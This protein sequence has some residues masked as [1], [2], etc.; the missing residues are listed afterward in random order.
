[1]DRKFSDQEIFRREKLKKLYESQKD[2]FAIDKFIRNFNSQ[3]FKDKYSE[4]TK[5]ELHEKKDEIIVA[6]RL[7]A[8]RQTFGVIKDFF[9][10]IQFYIGKKSIDPKY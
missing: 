9:G 4:F 1:M 10:K 8:I 6:G 7:I 3:S 5:E 2:P